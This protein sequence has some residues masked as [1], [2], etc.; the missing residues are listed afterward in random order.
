MT[1]RPSRLARS[2]RT[3]VPYLALAAGLVFVYLPILRS[4]ALF[5]DDYSN[6]IE[7]P[8]YAFLVGAV[9]RPVQYLLLDWIHRI[10]ADDVG[11]LLVV[12]VFFF[13]AWAALAAALVRSVRNGFGEWNAVALVLF[14]F[15]VPA[16]LI[17]V[18]WLSVAI[19]APAYLAAAGS[20]AT[21]YVLLGRARGTLARVALALATVSLVAIATLTYQIAV[22]LPLAL[23]VY[24]L[25]NEA[26]ERSVFRDAA[27]LY[28]LVFAGVVLSFV[29][30]R[31]LL[32]EAQLP[33]DGRVQ[34]ATN[35]L[36]SA[37]ALAL[38]FRIFSANFGL[39]YY[40]WGWLTREAAI[41]I[42]ALLTALAARAM[43][44][45]V[46]GPSA[47][48]EARTRWALVGAAFFAAGMI[49]ALDGSRELRSKPFLTLLILFVV[50]HVLRGTRA[51]AQLGPKRS[52]IWAAVA[53]TLVSGRHTLASG[54]VEYADAE[55]AHV[56]ETLSRA[57]ASA[58][59]R[60]HVVQPENACFSAPCYGWFEFNVKLSSSE[61]WVPRGM[62]QF[63]LARLGRPAQ[64]VEI[65]CSRGAPADPTAFV[66]DMRPLARRLLAERG[67]VVDLDTFRKRRL[68]AADVVG[69]A[70]LWLRVAD[71]ASGDAPDA[72]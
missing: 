62:V 9:G 66:V 33:M 7:A 27:I 29:V 23:L 68:R 72:K 26:R 63:A 38:P 17:S 39:H 59:S 15:S 52:L 61:D 34:S 16:F 44:R 56:R 28:A 2:A 49:F 5:N 1:R 36:A 8:E 45:D 13:V 31:I 47:T 25:L 70:G 67:E 41:L 53:L 43:W 3:L 54:L 35:R 50:L 10:V 55:L 40:Y 71:R 22:A 64:R 32:H 69:M 42:G 6:F 46:T 24:H 58:L 12:R 4:D 18:A 57:D 60:V 20:Y 19:N 11:W 65:T 30:L 37:R 21:G 14:T 48:R 51:W